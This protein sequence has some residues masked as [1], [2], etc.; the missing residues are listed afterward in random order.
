MTIPQLA[1]VLP[2]IVFPAATF[3]Q[4][5]RM[6]RQRSV[7][8]V[9]VSTWLLFGVANIA[10]YIYAEHYGEWQAIVGMLLTAVLDFAIV[11]LALIGFRTFHS[12]SD[13]LGLKPRPVVSAVARFETRSRAARA[14]YDARPRPSPP[15]A[16][17][18]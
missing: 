2:A 12:E 18:S 8:N 11:A 13:T 6:V 14:T 1:G 7:T 9:C 4:L 3:G 10:I 17:S 16:S 5:L 15:A